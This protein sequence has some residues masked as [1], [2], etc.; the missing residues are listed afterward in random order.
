MPET[1]DGIISN[2]CPP[3]GSQGIEGVPR[4]FPEFCFVDF[5]HHHKEEHCRPFGLDALWPGHTH[6]G[7]EFRSPW[8]RLHQARAVL[9]ARECNGFSCFASIQKYAK[10]EFSAG[11]DHVVAPFFDLDHLESEGER[12]RTDLLELVELLS[13]RGLSPTDF[14]IHYT[15]YKGFRLIIP[16]PVTG[17]KP[18]ADLTGFSK[19]LAREMMDSLPT[20]DLAVYGRRGVL[21]LVNTINEKTVSGTSK[22]YCIRLGLDEISLPIARLKE[23]AQEPR[24]EPDIWDF[25]SFAI[26]PRAAAWFAER[27]EEFQAL[28]KADEGK[29]IQSEDFKRLS[30]VPFCVGHLESHSISQDGD[31]QK[32]ALTLGT[33]LLAV[34]ATEDELRTRL[35]EFVRRIPPDLADSCVRDREANVEAV[36]RFLRNHPDDPRYGFSCRYPLS[37]GMPCV[38]PD[39][40][41]FGY[42]QGNHHR[43]F[44][45]A[46]DAKSSVVR[47]VVMTVS[48]IRRWLRSVVEQITHCGKIILFSGGPPGIG[49]THTLAEWVLGLRAIWLAQ[50]HQQ[51]DTPEKMAQQEG[52][53]VWR[54]PQLCPATCDRFEEA[55]VALNAGIDFKWVICPSCHQFKTGCRHWAGF[56]GSEGAT[57][58]LATQHYH[59][60]REKFYDNH[61]NPSR[62][63]EVFD[64]SPLESLRPERSLLSSRL[65]RYDE[66]IAQTLPIPVAHP[67]VS[68]PEG[69]IDVMPGIVRRNLEIHQ[70]VV[71]WLKQA[72][73]TAQNIVLPE[74]L[75]AGYQT[76]AADESL[77]WLYRTMNEHYKKDQRIRFFNY[78]EAV[79]ELITG[80]ARCARSE[81]FEKKEG[82]AITFFVDRPIPPGRTVIILDATGKKVVYDAIFGPD[83]VVEHR[84]P[85]AAHN[86]KIIQIIDASWSRAYLRY[87]LE[88]RRMKDGRM[89][90][91]ALK[92]P[93]LLKAIVGRHP[94]ACI[95]LISYKAFIKP[96]LAAIPEVHP[97]TRYFGAQRGSNTLE[98]RDVLI[99]VGI[100]R[101]PTHGLRRDAER[102]FGR[103]IPDEPEMTEVWTRVC[104]ENR[105]AWVLTLGYRGREMKVA[106]E[107]RVEA[108]LIQ[109]VGRSRFL[110]GDKFIYVLAN[111][112]LG[113]PGVTLVE[114]KDLMA[115]VREDSLFP[116]V[117]RRVQALEAAGQRV[118]VTAMAKDMQCSR[119]AVSRHLARIRAAQGHQDMGLPPRADGAETKGSPYPGGI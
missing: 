77:K 81:P 61:A 102:I 117:L 12:A 53:R 76:D 62:P 23:F 46:T 17:L 85:H 3:F 74:A 9:L 89:S 45:W 6:H 49:K 37:L 8:L 115:S 52:I 105:D 86:S 100:P 39:C 98:D 60:Y 11:E 51:L 18:A 34:G 36:V 87:D 1:S 58:I 25:T 57:S 10:P 116:E 95:G 48:A 83:R 2:P 70:Q 107:A 78:F 29:T 73:A 92:T 63:F 15:G 108:E 28:P 82:G 110:K 111:A 93:R 59:R 104:G 40:P 114:A 109:A 97:E 66:L 96:L 35:H 72:S 26:N 19:F 5:W 22:R 38:G 42:R 41:L 55:Q 43:K 4:H 103:E 14:V 56:Q 79:H 7:G 112:A 88:A 33:A 65:C 118:N 84:I 119:Q 31:R 64:E 47:H 99:I 16:A 30:K 80:Q 106:Y 101:I 44:V 24:G 75:V 90:K 32:A 68:L 91:P 13:R 94:G 54:A 21:R 20:L 113:L 69:V 27:Y 71:R 50:Q 67:K